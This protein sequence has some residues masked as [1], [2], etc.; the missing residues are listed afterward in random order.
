[1]D[2]IYEENKFHFSFIFCEFERF[3]IFDINY[4]FKI[5]VFFRRIDEY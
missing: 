1:M 4:V 3:C 5:F 2:F